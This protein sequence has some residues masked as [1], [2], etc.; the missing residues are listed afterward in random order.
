M[1]KFKKVNNLKVYFILMGICLFIHG[2][3]CHVCALRTTSM[4]DA[5]N[6]EQDMGRFN[7]GIDHVNSAG[8]TVIWLPEGE[9]TVLFNTTQGEAVRVVGRIPQATGKEQELAQFG[10]EILDSSQGFNIVEIRGVSAGEPKNFVLKR[11]ISEDMLRRFPGRYTL[12]NNGERT[13]FAM[14]LLGLLLKEE[15]KEYAIRLP[16]V[17]IVEDA[18]S[19]QRFIATEYIDNARPLKSRLLKIEQSAEM[20]RNK[21][22]ELLDVY[23]GFLLYMDDREFLLKEGGLIPFDLETALAPVFYQKKGKPTH[24][25]N[26]TG[27]FLRGEKSAYIQVAE[28]IKG[29]MLDENGRI[30]PDVRSEIRGI[31]QKSGLVSNNGEIRLGGD[32][33]EAV[34]ADR[35]LAFLEA[36]VN[37]MVYALNEE[38][39]PPAVIDFKTLGSGENL[40]GKQNLGVISD[41][42]PSE[43]ESRDNLKRVL[44]QAAFGRDE[45][46][47]ISFLVPEEGAATLE[48][49][50]PMPVNLITRDG[51]NFFD[52]LPRVF[53]IN[54]DVK[55]NDV[56]GS[57]VPYMSCVCV[58]IKGQRDG[59]T[60]M[61]FTHITELGR[62][63]EYVLRQA[64]NLDIEDPQIFFSTHG[65]ISDMTR[66]LDSVIEL[67]SP[68]RYPTVYKARESKKISVHKGAGKRYIFGNKEGLVIRQSDGQVRASRA[69][70]WSELAENPSIDWP[71]AGLNIP[72]RSRHGTSL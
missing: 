68:E 61:G 46:R 7:E 25:Y 67:A 3:A 66:E 9:R 1:I 69:L 19:G 63:L 64:D 36:Q 37:R 62:Q 18:E 33:L 29:F 57:G 65:L 21:N 70:S 43:R 39:R 35:I 51:F 56:M 53:N 13:L 15:F 52:A 72:L 8:Q 71:S 2:T 26:A 58:V 27:Y 31:I 5:S 50:R 10:K 60:I 59:K 24:A 22:H 23:C 55:D 47:V 42:Y 28:R 16:E 20:A 34:T 49:A 40:A 38:N 30:K 41:V 4:F 17:R 44:R 11:Q 32:V 14:G 12:R 6:K 54:K 48:S 45:G